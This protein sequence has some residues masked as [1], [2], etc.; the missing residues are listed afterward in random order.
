M[1]D[2][3]HSLLVLIFC[4]FR[5][6]FGVKEKINRNI[7]L[8]LADKTWLPNCFFLLKCDEN[9]FSRFHSRSMSL[10]YGYTM[11]K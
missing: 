1:Y 6:V 8:V 7:K 2:D 5:L 10:N 4:L 9:S 11:Q 3:W